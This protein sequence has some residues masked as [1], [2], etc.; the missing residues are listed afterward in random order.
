MSKP[1]TPTRFSP[2]L[3]DLRR[4]ALQT[5]RRVFML[6]CLV[7]PHEKVIFV[8]GGYLSFTSGATT[9][10]CRRLFSLLAGDDGFTR[11]ALMGLYQALGCPVA[12]PIF[13]PYMPGR[14][15][16]R[17]LLDRYVL[18][19]HQVRPASASFIPSD[20]LHTLAYSPPR[21]RRNNAFA[22]VIPCAFSIP[23]IRPTD[24]APS[25]PS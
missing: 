4:N 15:D 1:K 11:V 12:W 3:P 8:S 25:P 17:E 9:L 20:H 5:L 21:L 23:R 16:R 19:I 24:R 13:G 7:D 2:P 10:L 14:H 22:L 18:P 6:Q